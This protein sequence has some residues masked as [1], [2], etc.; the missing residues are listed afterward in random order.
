MRDLNN[1][2]SQVKLVADFINKDKASRLPHGVELFKCLKL[3]I[4]AKGLSFTRLGK[5]L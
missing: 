5:E 1:P 4:V 3:A 2:L